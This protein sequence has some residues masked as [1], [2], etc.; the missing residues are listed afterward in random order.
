MNIQTNL[1]NENKSLTPNAFWSVSQQNFDNN[2]V[3]FNYKEVYDHLPTFITTVAIWINK[4]HKARVKA[5]YY[6]PD[7]SG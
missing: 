1:E 6:F 2:T 3:Y 7:K 5:N 4:E